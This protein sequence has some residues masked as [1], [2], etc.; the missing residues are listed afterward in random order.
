MCAP[1]AG[2]GGAPSGCWSAPTTRSSTA[3]PV[4]P[5]L[6]APTVLTLLRLLPAH[7]GGVSRE[8]L[9]R[10]LEVIPPEWVD[11]ALARLLEAGMAAEQ[12]GLV[13]PLAPLKPL[14][15]K[16]ERLATRLNRQAQVR[17]QAM[18]LVKLLFRGP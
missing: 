13:V 1:P 18:E 14:A 2:A 5:E 16:M 7:P 17:D 9:H 12:D 6:F 11:R 15:Q 10:V 4:G 8:E 3:C